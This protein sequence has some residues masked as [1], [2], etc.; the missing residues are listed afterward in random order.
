ML[1]ASNLALRR[2]AGV[3]PLFFVSTNNSGTCND[4]E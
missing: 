1:D 3:M 4:P 2:N